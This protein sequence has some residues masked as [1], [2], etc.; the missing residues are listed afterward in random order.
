MLGKPGQPFRLTGETDRL[1]LQ[2]IAHEGTA[3]DAQARAELRGDIG[4]HAVVGS[5]G[6]RKERDRCRQPLRDPDDAPVVGAEV[7]APIRDAMR[8]VHD[9]QA[10]TQPDARQGRR[11]EPLVGQAFR[12]NEQHVDFVGLEA[13]LDCLPVLRILTVDACRPD[14][15]A[16]GRL[17]LVSHQRQQGTDE[18]SGTGPLIP[19]QPRGDEINQALAPA[20]PLHEQRSAPVL[21]RLEN[22]FELAVPERC[23]GPHHFAQQRFRTHG[24][25]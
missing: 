25:V 1:E 13:A 21:H 18:Q 14:A 10:D 6:G 19:K 22:G 12:R 5:G 20:G 4:R 8:F 7:V 15:D 11:Q 16:P 17:D 2:G 9:Q 23:A 3:D 24:E